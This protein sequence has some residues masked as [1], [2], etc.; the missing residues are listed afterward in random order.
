MIRAHL[1]DELCI[2]IGRAA[3][4]SEGLLGVMRRDEIEAGY[5]IVP[6]GAEKPFPVP[7]G[8]WDAA[9]ISIRGVKVRIVLV[10]AKKKGDHAFTRLIKSICDADL[11][12]AVIE[13]VGDIM[14]KI[15]KK[16]GWRGRRRNGSG[17]ESYMEYTPR[18]FKFQRLR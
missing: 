11:T 9:V 2:Q 3:L 18:A 5:T 10:A 12:P 4:D 17:W 1:L 13:P 6:I 16:W 14:P 8:D 15:M 7:A